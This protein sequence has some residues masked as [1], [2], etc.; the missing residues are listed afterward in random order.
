MASNPIAKLNPRKQ[1]Y[2]RA[3]AKGGTKKS[4]ALAAGYSASTAKNP[5]LIETADAR[6]AF[7][8][9]MRKAISPNRLAKVV[10]EGTE[11]MDTQFF[12][13]DG[14][15]VDSRNV[16]AWGERR[17]YAEL[18]AQFANYWSPRQEIEHTQKLDEGTARRLSDIAEKLGVM[19]LEYEDRRELRKSH[20]TLDAQQLTVAQVEDGDQ[21]AE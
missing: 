19:D 14:L 17:R 16:I 10:R 8:E 15:V 18:G 2:V 4:A 5:H 12:S 21:E 11:A 9:V 7:V 20:V 1:K 13:K 3:L 6:Q